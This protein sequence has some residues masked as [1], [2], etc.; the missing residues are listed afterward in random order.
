[1]VLQRSRPSKNQQ[2]KI[3]YMLPYKLASFA[4]IN[5]PICG[6]SPT[7][8]KSVWPPLRY[9][10]HQGIYDQNIAVF[11]VHH[12]KTHLHIMICSVCPNSQARKKLSCSSQNRE[13]FPLS[14]LYWLEEMQPGTAAMITAAKIVSPSAAVCVCAPVPL[15]V[16]SVCGMLWFLTGAKFSP[17]Q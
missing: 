9:S 3:S 8:S 1:M 17:G 12:I 15:C 16:L 13:N 7:L 6:P 14:S 4:I 11:P 10:I 5:L 2:T